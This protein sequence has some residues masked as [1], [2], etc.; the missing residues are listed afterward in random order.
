MLFHVSWEFIDTTEEGQ[1]RSLAVFS[2]WQPPEGAD[3]SK[4]FY[5]FGDG[6]GGVAIVAALLTSIGPTIWLNRFD[7]TA[8]MSDAGRSITGSRARTRALGGFVITQ[9]ALATVLI[10]AT[11]RLYTDYSIINRVDPGFV[12][13]D[14]TSAT[15][16]LGGM[17]YRGHCSTAGVV[18]WSS[19]EPNTGTSTSGGIVP[20]G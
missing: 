14:V 18:G 1:K 10:A 17:R 8:F 12:A 5:G 16:A 3:F 2:Q 4:G 11:A 19:S 20:D 9:L 6:S 13:S 15:I 7:L